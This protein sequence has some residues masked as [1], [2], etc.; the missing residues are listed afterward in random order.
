MK[1]LFPHPREPNRLSVASSLRVTI[2][3]K[4]NAVKVVYRHPDPVVARD[5]VNKLLD[6]FMER[7]VEDRLFGTNQAAGMLTVQ[8]EDLKNHAADAQRKLA[9]FQEE[10]NFVDADEKDNLTTA[11]LKIV[12]E[13]LAEAQADQIIKQAQV[14]SGSIRQPRTADLGG[15]H[16]D[17]TELCAHQET[18]LR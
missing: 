15:S 2:V 18:R 5:F 1:I 4:T 17:P 16:A 6:V 10:H 3:P 7:S 9:K 8:M 14:A 12:N 13:Q 11:G